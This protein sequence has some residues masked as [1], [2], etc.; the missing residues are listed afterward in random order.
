MRTPDQR[1]FEI[2]LPPT[3]LDT[4]H[5]VI[6]ASSRPRSSRSWNVTVISLSTMPWI[7]SSQSFGRICGIASAVSIR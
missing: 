5:S 3:G 1:A 6:Q 7:F 2:R 4:Q